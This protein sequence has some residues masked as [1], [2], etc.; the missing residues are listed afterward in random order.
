MPRKLRIQYSGAIYHLMNRGDR[1]EKI[2]K[3]DHERR[4]FL[5]TVGQ[6]CEKTGWQ[7]NACCLMS[8]HFHLVVETPQ[9]NLLVGMKWLLGTYTRRFSEGQR[10]QGGGCRLEFPSP[11]PVAGMMQL[12]TTDEPSAAEPQPRTEDEDRGIRNT[13]KS[14]AREKICAACENFQ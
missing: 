13:P 8:N 11:S 2:F 4:R 10:I 14:E 9:P 6:S 12:T 7:V 3:N 5:H 1:R